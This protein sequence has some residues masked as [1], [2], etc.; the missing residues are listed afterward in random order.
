LIERGNHGDWEEAEGGQKSSTRFAPAPGKEKR[1]DDG[2]A[3]AGAEKKGGK[4]KKKRQKE[5][6]SKRTGKCRSEAC[7][8]V[9]PTRAKREDPEEGGGKL[10]LGG[11][12]WGSAD[13]WY[14]FVSN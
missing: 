9:S 13:F 2:L 10:D 7:V 11:D 1:N 14:R 8:Q 5:W 3:P 6:K 4:K 12:A